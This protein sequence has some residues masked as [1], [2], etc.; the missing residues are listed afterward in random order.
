M[1]PSPPH[2][3]RIGVK[4]G[5]RILAHQDARGPVVVVALQSREAPPPGPQQGGERLN[6]YRQHMVWTF[7][8]GR[9]RMY[10][11]RYEA[12]DG[13]MLF[14]ENIRGNRI[15]QWTANSVGGTS[16]R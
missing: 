15:E 4:C 1:L 16:V 14:E 11:R 9:E 13:A 7:E 10:I 3:I 6:L 2:S 12:G 5:V 8:R